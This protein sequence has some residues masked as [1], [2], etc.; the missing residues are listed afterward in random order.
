MAWHDDVMCGVHM[1][2]VAYFPYLFS[3]FFVFL[4]LFS[5]DLSCC[6]VLCYVVLSCPVL[7]CL[8]LFVW[9]CCQHDTFQ[10][11]SLTSLVPIIVPFI[12][13]LVVVFVVVAI[14]YISLYVH[15]LLAAGSELLACF[16]SLLL[17]ACAC[18]CAA[19]LSSLYNVLRCDNH[20]QPR[21]HC[22]WIH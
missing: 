3:F 20:V 22:R 15:W 8:V 1:L 16:V 12:V 4:F 10:C 7:S 17:P 9:C 19:C 18:A 14:A 13:P 2:L 11:C 6:A 5:A 21:A